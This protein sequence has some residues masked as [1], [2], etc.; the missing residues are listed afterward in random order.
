MPSER[1]VE[2]SPAAR[3][4]LDKIFDYTADRWSLEQ[5]ITYTDRFDAAFARLGVDA[6]FARRRDDLPP[7]L[8]FVAVG[9]HYVFFK[10]SA[11]TVTI[12]RVLHQQMDAGRHLS[13][14]T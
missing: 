14:D 9:S 5:A 1:T 2:V 6:S 4:D 13:T 3:A 8:S 10:L 11:D 12:V 7:D